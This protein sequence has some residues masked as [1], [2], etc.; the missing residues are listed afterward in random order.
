MHMGAGAINRFTVALATKA[1]A[2]AVKESG[3]AQ[4]G[5]VIACDSRNHSMEFARVTACVLARE[6]VKAYLFDALRPTPELSFAVLELGC[7]AGVNIT[8]S[9]NTKEYNGYKAY[10]DHGAQIS[11]EQAKLIAKKC[12]EYD[13]LSALEGC[14]FDAFVKAG[15]ITVI[16]KEMDEKYLARVLKTSIIEGQA[17]QTAREMKLVYS[18][19]HGAGH[20]LVPEILAR[21]GFSCVTTVEEQMVLDGDFPTV[22]KPNPQDRGAFDLGIR[23]ARSIGSE[24]VIATDPDA[25]RAGI[26]IREK[27]GSFR[28]LTGNQIGCLLLQFILDAKQKANAMPK[29]PA[30]VMSLVSTNLADA[31]CQANGVTLFRVYTGF[32]YIGEK[33]AEF[34]A[35]GNYS[36][37][38]GFEESH[39]YLAGSYARDKDAV[40]AVMLIC[41]MAAFYKSCGM[42]LSDALAKLYE[43]YGFVGDFTYEMAITDVDFMA[44][45]A[46]V[47]EQYRREPLRTLD[48]EQVRVLED[49]ASQTRRDLV[50]QEET[51][52]CLPKENMLSFS[53]AE[54]TRVIV[55][56]SG[57]EPKIKL[58]VSLRADD[59]ESAEA[60]YRRVLDDA[61]RRR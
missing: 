16:G 10:W 22:T 7:R 59:A 50:R 33:I 37:L 14:D 18:P 42:T 17:R 61:L 54:G 9:H 48:G 26:A 6:G 32:K 8:A 55:R 1:L 4:R 2:Y 51:G 38:F 39:G 28:V 53:T 11:V 20:A 44:K 58:Y 27:D 46:S 47:M 40:G 15:A 24:A 13:L 21:D 36:Y 5:V 57:T 49:Y 45:M 41:E 30:V 29:H 60:K 56:P 19:L 25:D 52:I 34:E 12:Y 23:L 31:I 43:R 3:G 35:K